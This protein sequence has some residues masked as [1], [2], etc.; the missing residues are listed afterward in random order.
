[1][2][3]RPV[4]TPHERRPSGFS[5]ETMMKNLVEG[6][7]L[8]DAELELVFGKLPIVIGGNHPHTDIVIERSKR[9]SDSVALVMQ[10]RKKF[11]GLVPY[12]KEER[13]DL[14]VH[15]LTDFAHELAFFESEVLAGDSFVRE[16]TSNISHGTLLM[17]CDC[18]T[19]ELQASVF[20]IHAWNDEVISS[21]KIK[22]F[23]LRELIQVLLGFGLCEQG[24]RAR[25]LS[26]LH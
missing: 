19:Y 24:W 12:I 1:M 14:S 3:H 25:N 16:A 6:R 10:E 18:G 26:P 4:L 13:V 23:P 2:H 15:R 7:R 9:Y 21:V 22:L 11:L 20:D 8:M 17:R 5:F